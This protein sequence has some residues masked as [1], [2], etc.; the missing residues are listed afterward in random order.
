MQIQKKVETLIEQTDF[1]LKLQ[2]GALESTEKLFSNFIKTVEAKSQQKGISSDD[3]KSLSNIIKILSDKLS[4]ISEEML[5]DIEFLQKQLESL[6]KIAATKDASKA[7][8]MLDMIFDKDE[9]ILTTAEFKE[10]V[11]EDAEIAQQ[12]LE[13]VVSDLTEA[14][15]ENNIRDVELLLEAMGSEGEI[16]IDFEDDGECDEDECGSCEDSCCKSNKKNDGCCGS[17]KKSCK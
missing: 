14:L 9:E 2:Q 3:A 8:L 13:A 6:N 7:Q 17:G 15:N 10:S 11:S 16:E 12:D 1:L 4:A 5:S